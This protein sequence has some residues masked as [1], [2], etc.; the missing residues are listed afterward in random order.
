MNG[1]RLFLAR[2]MGLTL[3]LPSKLQVQELFYLAIKVVARPNVPEESEGAQ[4]DFNGVNIAEGIEL[5]VID[6]NKEDPKVF[7]LK[8]RVVID[9]KQG[10]VAPYDIDVE[11]AGIFV[12]TP[13]MPLEE[14]HEFVLINGCAVLYGAIRDQVHT[15]TTRSARGGLVLPTVNFLDYRGKVA[16]VTKKSEV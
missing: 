2:T 8:L 5:S 9:N 12:V 11:V 1:I 15:L 14:R 10:K 13:T 3:M 6:D 16:Q 7:A 4:F